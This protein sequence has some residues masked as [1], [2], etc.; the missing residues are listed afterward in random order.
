METLSLSQLLDRHELARLAWEAADEAGAFLRDQRPDRL[1]VFTKSSPTDVVTAMDRESE[2]LIVGRIL[3]QRPGDEVVGE[4]GSDRAGSTGVRWIIDPLD[5][6]VNYLF[7]IPTWGVSVGVHRD[8]AGE[9]GVI[10][11]PDFHESFLGIRGEGAWRIRGDS[12]ERL[13]GR[14]TPSLDQALVATG[15]G[16][17]PERRLAQVAVLEGLITRVRDIRRT[18]C[19]TIDFTWLAMGRLDAYYERGI[20]PWDYAAGL[21]IAAEAGARTWLTSL[22]GSGDTV[23]CAMPTIFDEL[24]D[25]LLGLGVDSGP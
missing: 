8:G 17:A 10:A 24:H 18:G 25:L 3:A 14:S 16:Y 7:G 5:G 1:E 15:F 19:A 20:H 23:V 4:E 22:P 21:V 6:T 2:K 13:M 9:V 12:A 11:T